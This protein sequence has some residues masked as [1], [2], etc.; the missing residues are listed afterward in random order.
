MSTADPYI[1][2]IA[3][4]R[5]I[6]PNE[7]YVKKPLLGIYYILFDFGCWL[8]AVGLYSLIENK[9]IFIKILYWLSSGF[10]MWCQF[11]NGHDCGHGSFSD[12][13]LLNT[14]MGH[15]SHTSLLVPFATWAESHRRH[16]LG[17]NHIE[18]DYS[19][20]FVDDPEK[21]YYFKIVEC[22]GTYSL[23][24]WFFYMVGLPDGGH[25]IPIGG[26]LWNEDYDFYTHIHCIFSSV[27]VFGWFYYIMSLCE[28]NFYTFMEWYG[29]S[30]MVFS[31][32]ITTVTYLQHH[33]NI[34]E[35]TIVYDDS[36]W[37]FIKGA[38]QTVD[39]SYGWIIDKL[40]HN[41]TNGHIVHHIFFT[42]IPHYHLETATKHLY[43]YLKE[44]GIEYKY[45]YSPYFFIDIFRIT[46]NHMSEA[47]LEK[48]ISLKSE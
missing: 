18:K 32:W 1:L 15:I 4:L 23:F 38:L 14:I 5:Q 31:W 42:K 26:R 9:T 17:H 35:D 20:P 43:K 7:C 21:K 37:S 34:A 2:D 39:R 10:F 22:T 29:G 47:K 27:L 12:S 45:K 36:S 3:K 24:G 30:W 48:N 46:M 16:H 6:I 41:I 33:D 19:H 11:M 8:S 13:Q 44:N 28:F 40:T 25:W